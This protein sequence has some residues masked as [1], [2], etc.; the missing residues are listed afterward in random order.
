M[1]NIT[2][3]LDSLLHYPRPS[4]SSAVRRSRHPRPLAVRPPR[5]HCAAGA[6][7]GGPGPARKPRPTAPRSRPPSPSQSITA[8]DGALSCGRAAMHT[9]DFSRDATRPP[10]TAGSL[11]RVVCQT[12]A[13]CAGMQASERVPSGRPSELGKPGASTSPG[14]ATPRR[15]IH[16]HIRQTDGLLNFGHGGGRHQSSEVPGVPETRSVE[17]LRMGARTNLAESNGRQK[18][19]AQSKFRCLIIKIRCRIRFLEGSPANHAALLPDWSAG[20][21]DSR[22]PEEA[23][24]TPRRS[25]PKAP[26]DSHPMASCRVQTHIRLR[27][28]PPTET[29]SL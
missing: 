7:P 23:L 14:D 11:G 10:T 6:R 12:R 15:F 4:L 5:R 26:P 19:A 9:P 16:L 20:L 13:C 3:A 17:W 25:D 8:R 1:S 28:G 18:P 2:F 29:G 22:G 27:A 24:S 21:N